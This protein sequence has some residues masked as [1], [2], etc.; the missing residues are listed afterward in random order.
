MGIVKIILILILVFQLPPRAVAKF[1]GNTVISR[2][3]QKYYENKIR[4]EGCEEI[5]TVE[6]ENDYILIYGIKVII[7]E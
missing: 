2:K 4:A 7:G 6:L 5:R 3:Y 1:C